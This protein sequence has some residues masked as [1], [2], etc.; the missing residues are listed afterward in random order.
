VVVIETYVA[1]FFTFQSAPPLMGTAPSFCNKISMNYLINQVLSGNTRSKGSW[2][3][4]FGKPICLIVVLVAVGCATVPHS[5][6][7]QF[8]MVS[9]QQLSAL[10]LKAFNEVV[11]KEPP[12]KDQRLNEIVRKVAERVSKAAEL[13]DKPKFD[14]D[15][16]VIDRDTPNAFCLPGGKIVV[17]TGM[18]PYA[19]NEAG[20]AAVIAH[21]TAHAVARHSGERLSQQLALKGAMTVGGEVLKKDDGSL[22]TK[23]RVALGALGMGGTVGIML[24]Y[25]R[26]HELEADRIGQLYMA[27]AGYDPSE[28]GRLWDRMSKIKKP[29][30]PVWLSTHPADEER[31]R[32]LKE[33]LPEAQKLYAEAPTKYGVGAPL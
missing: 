22:D 2:A 12:S 17:C 13:I 19:R 11:A 1:A 14:W 23:A 5:G 33:F 31:V 6:R 32:K 29:P 20:L 24:P 27:A 3:G 10:A 18:V 21:E 15:V 4:F 28:A 30:I 8:N 25:S 7:R 9:D 26:V 16:R